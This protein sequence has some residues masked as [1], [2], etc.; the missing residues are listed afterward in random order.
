MFKLRRIVTSQRL[1]LRS[2]K[3][4]RQ[5]QI[6]YWWLAALFAQTLHQSSFFSR[7]PSLSLALSLSPFTNSLLVSSCSSS[8][9]L[10]SSLGRDNNWRMHFFRIK[11]KPPKKRQSS[12]VA[13]PI[14]LPATTDRR[15]QLPETSI[16]Q[17]PI[18]SSLWQQLPFGKKVSEIINV[19]SSWSPLDRTC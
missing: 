17:P 16:R 19:T 18:K 4:N 3:F 14:S 12:V 7:A 8:L 13:G 1:I 15:T 2:R 11:I 6:D 5:K 10:E 9:G